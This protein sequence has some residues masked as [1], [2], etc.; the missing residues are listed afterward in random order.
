[1]DLRIRKSLHKKY[2]SSLMK[3][4][5]ERPTNENVIVYKYFDFHE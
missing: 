1:M 3:M 4:P 5:A 2:R